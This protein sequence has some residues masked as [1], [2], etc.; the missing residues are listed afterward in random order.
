LADE[1]DVAVDAS[2]PKQARPRQNGILHSLAGEAEETMEAAAQKTHESSLSAGNDI[3]A[4]T[5]NIANEASQ[6]PPL[7]SS[8]SA[9]GIKSNVKPRRSSS[10]IS[11]VRSITKESP[12]TP[13]PKPLARSIWP[14]TP[15]FTF[16][17]GEV[18]IP[19]EPTQTKAKVPPG[20][21]FGSNDDDLQSV[22]L[23]SED[24][25]GTSHHK[26]RSA[27]VPHAPSSGGFVGTL[28]RVSLLFSHDI[29][30]ELEATNRT[31]EAASALLDEA[32]TTDVFGD[33]IHLE[34]EAANITQAAGSA[35]LDEVLTMDNSSFFHES[36]ASLE[37]VREEEGEDAEIMFRSPSKRNYNTRDETAKQNSSMSSISA[38]ELSVDSMLEGE[39]QNM[40]RSPYLIATKRKYNTRDEAAKQNHN[41][42]SSISAGEISLVEPDTIA[43]E[44]E[45]ESSSEENA[46][47]G[48]IGEAYTI[49]EE[50]LSSIPILEDTSEAEEL[51]IHLDEDNI[52]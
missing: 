25:D 50:E 49:K 12:Q 30:Q 46:D 1:V 52:Y 43:E 28:R 14:P 47:E 39:A 37:S 2:P 42:M 23:K 7:A 11:S 19:A 27:E 48:S 4:I 20:P 29:Q 6:Q 36:E 22:D 40:L 16:L 45:E 8:V 21:P 13:V 3:L 15:V 35:L 34:L 32:L 9:S 24:L 5:N 31:Q 33:D 10:S 18:W 17:S 51:S 38:G 44:P 41:S 26:N